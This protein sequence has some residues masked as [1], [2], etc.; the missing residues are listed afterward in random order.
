MGAAGYRT[1]Y[2]PRVSPARSSR[3]PL[4]AEP[5]ALRATLLGWYDTHHRDFPWRR[6][7]DPYAVLVSEVM[8]QQTQASRVEIAFPRFLERFPTVDA[9]ARAASRDVLVAWSGL[10]YNRRAL[11]LQRAAA[12]LAAG[13]WPG[14]VA[15]LETLPGVGPYTARAVASLAFGQP[16]G[17]VDTNVRRW[18]TRRFGLDSR[19]PPA[20]LQGLADDLAAA[21]DDG[22][23]DAWTHASMEFGA[24]VCRSRAPRCASCPISEGCPS[25]NGAARVPVP[26]QAPFV[27][28]DRALRG[29]L[30]RTLVGAPGHSLPIRQARALF[31]RGAATRLIGE[32][33]REGLVHRSGAELRLGGRDATGGTATIG[34]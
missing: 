17:V 6:T 27:G 20:G 34:P 29:D 28:S 33:E 23:A 1:R 10:G 30:L 14:D 22:R 11:A 21:G 25:R 9:L 15:G 3:N 24:N 13:G 16:L 32:L 5:A 12:A 7:R 31:P 18:L 8:L 19:T 26:H 2:P 4:A